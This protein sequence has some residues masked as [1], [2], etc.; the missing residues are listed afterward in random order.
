MIGNR[1][2]NVEAGRAAGIALFLYSGGNLFEFTKAEITYHF[3]MEP[4]A[5]KALLAS[6][7]E[8]KVKLVNY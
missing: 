4:V 8:A 6:Q 7:F 1:D 2:R 3:E 5:E